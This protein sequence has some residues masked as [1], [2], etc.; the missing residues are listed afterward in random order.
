MEK[1]GKKTPEMV[2]M[3]DGLI[4]F[5]GAGLRFQYHSRPYLTRYTEAQQADLAKVWD[6]LPAA[7]QCWVP[8]EVRADAAGAEL[9]LE[10]RYCGRIGES[11][12]ARRGELQ[13]WKRAARCAASGSFTRANSGMFL[14]LDVRRIAR[15]GVM[16]EASVSLKPGPQQVKASADGGRGRCGQCGCRRRRR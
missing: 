12:S 1:D 11:E 8:L 4:E 16:K 6:T 13:S 7:S 2:P 10:G 9:W 15:P 5:T 3:A 14:P